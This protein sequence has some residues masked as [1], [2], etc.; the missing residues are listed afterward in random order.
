M[1][2]LDSCTD[3]YRTV[4]AFRKHL[5]REHAEHWNSASG[6]KQS[7]ATVVVSKQDNND[8]DDVHS[9][10][11]V[12]EEVNLSVSQHKQQLAKCIGFS[13][14]KTMEMHMLPKSVNAFIFDNT[15]ELV[16]VSQFG[17]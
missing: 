11:D 6:Q 3:T 14:L 4:D 17:L 12:D 10:M 8:D 5:A 9:N 13:K 2:N 1:C 15:R 16:N 7:C